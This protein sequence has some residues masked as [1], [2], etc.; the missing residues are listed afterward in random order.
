MGAL[1][2]CR[3]LMNILVLLWPD[4]RPMLSHSV[5]MTLGHFITLR[6]SKL[7]SLRGCICKGRILICGLACRLWMQTEKQGRD[8][9]TIHVPF[10]AA[11]IEHSHNFV[12]G[13]NARL[14][15]YGHP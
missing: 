1:L 12:E 3:S 11:F 13:N 2:D 8:Y 10:A 15:G 5:R 14:I 9:S 4:S 6:I 7:T